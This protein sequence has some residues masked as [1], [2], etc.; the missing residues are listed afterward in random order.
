M[1]KVAVAGGTGDVGRTI[2]EVIKN[3]PRHEAVVFTRKATGIS[4]GIP[5]VVVDYEDV[6]SLRHILEEHKIH[7]VISALGYDGDTLSTS[8]L[9]LIQAA[10]ASTSTKRFAPSAFACAYT[11]DMIETFPALHDYFHAI[12]ELKKS[13]LQ[14]TIF[15]NG[16]FMDYLAPGKIKSYLR[17]LPS[18]IDIDNKMAAIPGNGNVP[19]TFTYSFDAAR[20]VV[21]SLDL[22]DWPEE[23]RMAGD[24]LTW[25]NLILLAEEISGSKFKVFHDDI[26][27]LKRAEVTELP[28]HAIAYEHMSKSAFQAM[29]AAFGLWT[30]DPKI[31][32]VSGELNAKFRDIQ[33][34]TVRSLFKKCWSQE[35]LSGTDKR[36]YL[37][38]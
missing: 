28:I 25:N 27:K 20:F 5:S 10:D 34:L 3:N 12:E 19:I 38:V 22:E 13:T 30:Q 24:I 8:Q 18:V 31:M 26:A 11:P 36:G 37:R 4:L 7:T 21:G 2:L 16:Y 23:S 29:S 33:P 9:N 17:P 15:M 35:T 1:V 14:W 6:D 32:H